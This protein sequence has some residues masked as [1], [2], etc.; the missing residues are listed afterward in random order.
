MAIKLDLEKAYDFLNWDYIKQCLAHF[1]FDCKWIDLIME[2]ITSVNF[3]LK[4]N[5]RM[6]PPFIPRR[7]IRQGDPLS[8]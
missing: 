2:C 1:G 3:S 4:I 8:P 6:Q 7:G 5:G